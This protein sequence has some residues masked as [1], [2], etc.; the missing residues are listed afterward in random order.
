MRTLTTIAPQ[1]WLFSARE[2]SGDSFERVDGHYVGHDGFVVPNDFAEFYQRFPDHI[3]RWIKRHAGR[4]SSKEDID[5]W[6]QDL[7]AHMSSLPP[8]SKYRGAWKTRCHSELRSVPTLWS[9]PAAL[10]ELHQSVSRKQ[11]SNDPRVP[12]ERPY[13]S[14]RVA[15]IFGN[16]WRGLRR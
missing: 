3:K 16:G 8:S 5:D 1:Q 14:C 4:C 15:L 12:Y 2:Y 10:P 13:V 9:E 7:C 6:T 11:V